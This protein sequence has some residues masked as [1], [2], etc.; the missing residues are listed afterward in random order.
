MSS[1]GKVVGTIALLALA[2]VGL[3]MSLC[4]GVVTVGGLATQG[5]SGILVLSVPSLLG[6][7]AVVWF[8]ARKALQRVRTPP[9]S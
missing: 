5:M 2:A 4:G 7:I 3:L 9:E 8:A 6:G 1:F